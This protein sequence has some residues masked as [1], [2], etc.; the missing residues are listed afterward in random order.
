MASAAGALLL[1]LGTT[2]CSSQERN[3]EIPSALCGT[4]VSPDL[5][6]PLLPPGDRISSTLSDRVEGV[7]RCLVDVDGQQVLALSTEWWK[8]GTSLGKAALVIPNVDPDD[9]ETEDGRYLYSDTGAIGKVT[10]PNPRKDDGDLFVAAR[11]NEP[12]RPDEAAMK[13]LIA[14]YAEAVGKS[15]ECT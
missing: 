7:K 2:A 10:C 15:G 13:K 6:T 5:T 14:A 3:Y 8:K 11:V 1:C 9:K 12:G 4:A